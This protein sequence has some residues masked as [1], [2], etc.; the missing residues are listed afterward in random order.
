M[1]ITICLNKML[2]K[3]ATFNWTEQCEKAFKLLKGE[4]TRM[5]VLQFPNPNKPFQLFTDVSKYSYSRILHQRK[6]GQPSAD[7]LVLIPIVYFSGTFNKMQQ[8]CNTTQ[9]ECY[10][11]YRSVKNLPSI[12]MVQTAHNIAV[13]NPKPRSLQQA[14]LV[15][16]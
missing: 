4:L 2:R 9:K 8:L 1:D 5:S 16:F 10:E 15:M 13:I 7:D 3:G 11:V 6:E 14:C 12:L